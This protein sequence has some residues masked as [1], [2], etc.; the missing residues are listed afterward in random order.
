MV[1][2]KNRIL[3][4]VLNLFVTVAIFDAANIFTGMKLKLFLFL[5]LCL[6]LLYGKKINIKYLK[7]LCIIECISLLSFL[8][9]RLYGFN[10]EVN[11]LQQ[12]LTTFFLLSLLLWDKY[13][14]INKIIWL[15]SILLSVAT[16]IC[17]VII[18][19]FPELRILLEEFAYSKEP[20]VIYLSERTF[21]GR[22]FVSVYYTPLIFIVIP[23]CVNIFKLLNQRKNRLINFFLSLLF[24]TALFC[25]GNRTCLLSIIMIIGGALLYRIWCTHRW[26]FHI[27]IPFVFCILAMLMYNL[28]TDEESSNETKLDHMETYYQL[29]SKSP[30]VYITGMGPGGMVYSKGF[31]SEVPLMEW[32]YLELLRFYGIGC[33][34]ILFVCFYP[35]YFLWKKKAVYPLGIPISIGGAIYMFASATNPYLINSTGMIVLIYMYTYMEHGRYDKN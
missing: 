13:I 14:N 33:L 24:C 19:N 29:L 28:M 15:P 4:F 21:L 16:I 3:N 22:E 31:G 12:Y 27:I 18:L 7:I 34:V 6:L 10:H 26:L 25:G 35:I 2:R 20:P 32:T 1:I 9:G 17:Y 23:A 5:L 11:F 30:Q 8:W